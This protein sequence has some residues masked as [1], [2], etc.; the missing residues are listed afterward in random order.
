GTR[1]WEKTNVEPRK[2]LWCTFSQRL[3]NST[4]Q[5][6]LFCSVVFS[7]KMIRVTRNRGPEGRPL[8]HGRPEGEHLSP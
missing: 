3:L 7:I 2:G 6:S 5:G 1:S 4:Y 8:G